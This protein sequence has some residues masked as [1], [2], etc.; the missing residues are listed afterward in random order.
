MDV[1][2]LVIASFTGLALAAF[3][4]LTY[5]LSRQL[6]ELQYAPV[7]EVYPVNAPK[8][9]SFEEGGFK[10]D[11]VRWEI[12]IMN[13]GNVP[14][15]ADNISVMIKLTPPHDS[16]EGAWTGVGKLCELYDE[17][18]NRIDRGVAVNAN[19][20]CRVTVFLCA[21]ERRKEEHKILKPGENA[22][23]AI[24]VFQRRKLGK[25]SGL[26][27]VVSEKFAVPAKFGRESL[28]RLV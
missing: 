7:L 15:W 19:D 6:A 4:L 28:A 14:I 8:T 3:A 20:Q 21:E 24:E 10:Y 22:I 27:R 12:C 13:P 18:R 2:Q 16:W 23:M 26:V 25:K 1:A 11:G 5:R 17:N 9:G